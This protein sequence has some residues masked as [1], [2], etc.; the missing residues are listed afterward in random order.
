MVVRLSTKG[1]LVIPHQIRKAL[2]LKPGMEFD[3]RL[4]GEQ[5][6]FTPLEH[7]VLLDELYGKYGQTDLLS[8]LEAEHQR[9][10]DRESSR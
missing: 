6:I 4:D 7:T 2:G 9:E 3:V 8:D 5:I 1:Q 10:L